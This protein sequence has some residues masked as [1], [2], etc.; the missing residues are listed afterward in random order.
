VTD[1]EAEP[2]AGASVADG[3]KFSAS[4]PGRMVMSLYP[5]P[6]PASIADLAEAWKLHPLLVEDPASKGSIVITECHR[7]TEAPG[8]QRPIERRELS[9]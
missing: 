2:I 3:L 7:V 8:D 6:S 5:A 9:R 1:G 4:N